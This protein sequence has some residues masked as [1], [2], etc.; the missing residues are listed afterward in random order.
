MIHPTDLRRRRK[1]CRPAVERLATCGRTPIAVCNACGGSR[2]AVLAERDRYGVAVRTALCLGCGLVYLL[3]PLTP[4]A[5]ADF[6]A[7][8]GYRELTGR[9][10]RRRRALA[11]VRAGQQDYAARVFAAL[12][13]HLRPATAE[14]SGARARLLDIG[15]STGLVADRFRQRLGFDAV[16]LD[17]AAK[18]LRQPETRGMRRVAS[19]FEEFEPDGEYSLI[20]LCRTI[21]HLLDLRRSLEKVRELLAPG[22]VFFCD[23]ADFFEIC[24]VEG[25]PEAVSRID[26]C[27]WLAQETARVIFRRAGLRTVAI[28]SGAPF[29]Q[30]SF[31]L[32][33][34]EQDPEARLPPG[35]I[36]A[37]LRR[38]REIGSDWQIQGRRPL[39]P[40]DWLR[41]RGHRLKKRL[42]GRA[43]A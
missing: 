9:F 14:G 34:G 10:S 13:P 38:L 21:E 3:E 32:R 18:E 19:S 28:H 24:R 36:D 31:V 43:G 27:F 22:G 33:R 30:L 26:H 6:Y 1:R 12:E 41:R 37:R 7:S 25:P 23:V 29:E 4:E 11:Q 40:I 20:L 15:A 16:L 35:W 39:D 2:K 5:Y 17:P 42:A 8:G